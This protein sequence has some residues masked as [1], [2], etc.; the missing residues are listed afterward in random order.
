M[1]TG[2]NQLSNGFYPKLGIARPPQK[3]KSTPEGSYM[4]FVK[5]VYTPSV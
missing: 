3:H 2:I 5:L 1:R 4:E